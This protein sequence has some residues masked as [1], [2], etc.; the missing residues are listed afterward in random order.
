[1]DKGDIVELAAADSKFYKELYKGYDLKDFKRLPIISKHMLLDNLETS[2]V[3][4]GIDTI[5]GAVFA[6]LTS[7]TSSQVAIFYRS[8][9]EIEQSASRFAKTAF[10]LNQGERKDRVAII[11]NYTLAYTFARHFAKAGVVVFLGNPYDLQTTAMVIMEAKINAIRTTPPVA[12]KIASMLNILGY[13]GIDKW[14]LAGSVLSGPVRKKLQ[15]LYPKAKIIQQYGMAETAISMYQCRHTIESNIYHIF[16][17]D[18]Y[19]EF[20]ADNNKYA[21]ECEVGRLIITKLSTENP[22]IRYD[23]EDLFR[24][25]G[26]CDCGMREYHM[27]GRASDEIKVKG[28]TIFKD[29]I[30]D[31][32]KSIKQYITGDYQITVEEVDDDDLVKSKFTLYVELLPEYVDRGVLPTLAN[33][34]ANNF[35]ISEE[36][37]WSEGVGL[38][39]FCPME[40]VNKKLNGEKTK[41][42]YDR[43]FGGRK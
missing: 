13:D 36:Y 21:E 18:F 10:Y 37:T 22:I 7:G 4:F 31:A 5:E 33:T 17:K 30:D 19:Y 41:V 14:L 42:V 3:D 15:E 11:N 12:L 32:I 6:R 20:I 43:R 16:P 40:V 38:G 39:L 9:K 1:M 28:I 29:R 2:N 8:E 24:V 35:E 34:F 26:I 27:V 25:G 23:T